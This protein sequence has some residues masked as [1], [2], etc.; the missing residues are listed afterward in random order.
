MKQPRYFALNRDA[1]KRGFTDTW[2]RASEI[3]ARAGQSKQKA[4]LIPIFVEWGFAEV[5]YERIGGALIGFYR[6]KQP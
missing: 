2:S 6:R 4:S 3:A 1:L 5:R